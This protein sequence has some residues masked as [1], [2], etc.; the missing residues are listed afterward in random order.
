MNR[1]LFSGLVISGLLHFALVTWG[2]K[3]PA[4]AHPPR[5]KDTGVIIDLPPVDQDDPPVKVDDLPKDT[6]Q[7]MAP[8]SLPDVPSVVP[9]NAFTEPLSPPAPPNLTS[10]NIGTIPVTNPA[11]EWRNKRIDVFTPDQLSQKPSARVQ[12]QPAY[13]Y[14]MSRA[15]ISG[16]VVVEF[17]INEAGDVIDTRVV[18]SS[19]REFEA[20]ATQAVM[21]WKFRAGRKDGK[22]VKVRASQLLSF[23]LEEANGK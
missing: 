16:E 13:P 23:N 11:T 19:H 12:P 9:V 10:A 8:P 6:P 20:A 14:E 4:P 22:A 5:P 2:D 21:K 7:Q 3:A 15:G 1:D 17:I 18:S